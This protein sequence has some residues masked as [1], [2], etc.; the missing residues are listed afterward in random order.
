MVNHSPTTKV[1]KVKM[2]LQ[3][4][5]GITVFYNPLGTFMN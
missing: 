2:P 1:L 5:R 3:L 4:S